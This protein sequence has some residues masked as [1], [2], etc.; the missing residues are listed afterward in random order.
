MNAGNTLLQK[1]LQAQS[2]LLLAVLIVLWSGTQ[3]SKG[4]CCCSP[5]STPVM[6]PPKILSYDTNGNPIEWT[7]TGSTATTGMPATPNDVYEDGDGNTFVIARNDD[8]SIGYTVNGGFFS[9]ANGYYD[10]I[11]RPTYWD[12]GFLKDFRPANTD[13]SPG[14][15]STGQSTYMVYDEAWTFYANVD[16]ADYYL[17]PAYG[18]LLEID[19][20]DVRMVR[21]SVTGETTGTYSGDNTFTG[22]DIAI[23]MTGPSF[24]SSSLLVN[25][26]GFGWLYGKEYGNH[27]YDVYAN[28]DLSKS[29][30]IDG[31]DDS[32]TQTVTFS[33]STGTYSDG[34][35]DVPGVDFGDTTPP[36]PP[37]EHSSFFPG[38]NVW[39]NGIQFTFNSGTA[40]LLWDGMGG[41]IT[42]EVTET[43]YSGTG[44]FTAL[45]TYDPLHIDD[46][47]S[48]SGSD[49]T[50]GDLNQFDQNLGSIGSLFGELGLSWSLTGP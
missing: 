6:G 10:G 42:Q 8:G 17:G 13:D 50:L 37:Y 22:V 33:S 1:H 24:A 41:T 44:S 39:V 12:Y 11:F 46:G 4:Q 14:T 31:D 7:Y 5:P 9:N 43:F 15:P 29:L 47:Y 32:T 3:E 34:D 19:G 25:G 35:F 20:G 40:T 38:D 26:E 21:N 2:Y 18:D 28:W 36:Q 49:A 45:I 30:T 23:A 48:I 16:G 27:I